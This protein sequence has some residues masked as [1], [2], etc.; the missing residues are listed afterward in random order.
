MQY[1]DQ[2]IFFPECITVSFSLSISPKWLS[3]ITWHSSNPNPSPCQADR[4]QPRSRWWWTGPPTSSSGSASNPC[5]CW[6]GPGSSWSSSSSSSSSSSTS[7]SSCR[8]PRARRLTKS[9]LASE[10]RSNSSQQPIRWED[11]LTPVL[12]LVNSIRTLSAVLSQGP[13]TPHRSSVREISSSFSSLEF[14][15]SFRLFRNSWK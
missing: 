10:S 8:R 11:S 3:T 4:Q 7:P 5:S 1:S 15:G 6:W 13:K 14:Q 9:Q 2:W 12:W